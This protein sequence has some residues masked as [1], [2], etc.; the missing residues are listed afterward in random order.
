ML[1]GL[2]KIDWSRLNHAYGAASDVPGQ[3]RDLV[4]P[5]AK[6]RDHALWSLY[7]NIFHQGTRYQAT[8]YAVPFLFEIAENQK[9]P[10]RHQII[11]LLVS[12]ALGYAE[13][14]LPYGIDPD[15][16]FTSGEDTPPRMRTRQ[17]SRKQRMRAM[18]TRNTPARETG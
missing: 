17:R 7:G 3:I 18:R 2:D 16:V 11:E 14:Y 15:Q 4:S 5:N 13:E 1:E 10:D 12:L 9:S 8:A 6:K